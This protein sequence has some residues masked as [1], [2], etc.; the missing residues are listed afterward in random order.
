[1]RI[2]QFLTM[3]VT[4]VL[5]FSWG[6]ATD[7]ASAQSDAWKTYTHS[8]CIR[9]LVVVGDN[10]WA[11]TCGGVVQWH[12]TDGSYTKYI[13]DD[14]L[15]S[16]NVWAVA[17]DIEGTLWF[18]TTQGVSVYDG[19][20]WTTYT[21]SDGLISNVINHIAID[22][23]GGKWFT[24]K[25]GISH[26]DGE[27]WTTYTS[28]DGLSDNEVSEI[29]VDPQ[30]DVWVVAQ[31]GLNRFNGQTWKQY[32]IQDGIKSRIRSLAIDNA[33]NIWAGSYDSVL[34]FNGH[35]W[36]T[37][38]VDETITSGNI[39]E[40]FVDNK[41]NVWAKI[42]NSWDDS[43][44]KFDGQVWSM[45]TPENRFKDQ[46]IRTIVGDE[47]GNIWVGTRHGLH[48]FDGDQWSR[49]L[50]LDEPANDAI[51]KIETDGQGNIWAAS[52][53]YLMEFDGQTWTTH[54]IETRNGEEI[55][56]LTVTKNGD[57][58]IG[59]RY[60]G[61]K[62]YD[63]NSWITYRAADSLVGDSIVATAIDANDHIWVG[64][65]Y[66]GLS[67]FDGHS[68]TSY[69]IADGL[70]GN[71][72]KALA[73]DKAGNVWVSATTWIGGYR[74]GVSRFDGTTWKTYTVENGLAANYV[75]TI[76]VGANGDVWF[77]TEQGVTKFDGK[78]WQTYTTEDGLTSNKVRFIADDGNN[79]WINNS[80]F[81][82]CSSSTYTAN[83]AGPK[84]YDSVV[85]IHGDRWFS[86]SRGISR[87]KGDY[88]VINTAVKADEN[89]AVKALLSGPGERGRLYALTDEGELSTLFI[90]DDFG[91]SW[92]PFEGGL[93]VDASCVNNIN[94]D[95]ATGTLYLS[96]CKGLYRWQG[97]AWELVS[98]Q[99]TGMVS[100]PYNQSE[101]FWA[102]MPTGETP[103]PVVYSD[104]SGET[105]RAASRYLAHSSGVAQI[106]PYPKDPDTLFA[107][108]WPPYAESQLRR[109]TTNAGGQWEN[110]PGPFQTSAIDP[111]FTIDGASGTLYV[112]TNDQ[113]GQLWRSCHPT[114][115]DANAIDWELL[116]NFGETIEVEIL[117]SGWSPNGQAIYANLK[118]TTL[119]HEVVLHRSLDG[120]Y[121]WRPLPIAP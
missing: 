19:T 54:S 12:R 25:K 107:T 65:R 13:N 66:N 76:S 26:F 86:T 43:L 39:W 56:T 78:T 95:Y 74:S 87:F 94:L 5:L 106:M 79:P 48:K 96:S 100:L 81:D 63:G 6:I 49:H 98:S 51:G 82:G 121:S 88:S 42:S 92:Q 14:G 70:V 109:G 102:T 22:G 46:G 68:W 114:V 59:T 23:A 38:T 62:K 31:K 45:P 57:V 80:R 52:R 110:V 10:V 84:I 115:S 89:M 29:V 120:G 85:D 105:W 58:W 60:K 73:V 16:N 112:T 55:I 97:E 103:F 104:N 20:T 2:K 50:T 108:V 21:T 44:A 91:A 24:T 64:T 17:V 119:S 1:M 3:I 30:G 77:G 53:H 18:G 72:I 11:A 67:R 4:V 99:E 111:N 35:Q 36:I 41:N 40:I 28:K 32:G 9:D 118:D 113:Q 47:T 27:V 33:G 93:P 7:P 15:I 83:L 61:V 71:D 34:Q 101:T 117:A 90:S 69:Q 8:N 75:S 116:H 37:Y